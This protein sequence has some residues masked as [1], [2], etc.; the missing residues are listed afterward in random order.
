MTLDFI[1]KRYGQLPSQVL[2][3]GTS[4]D[5]FVAEIG[6]GYENYINEKHSGQTV[7]P[8]LSQDEMKRMI[9]QVKER[10]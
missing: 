7:T 4:I 5:I 10:K 1:S 8:K 6:V 2:K 9:N 3:Q